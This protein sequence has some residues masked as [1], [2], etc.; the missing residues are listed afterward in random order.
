MQH[1]R[2]LGRE[3]KARAEHDVPPVVEDRVVVAE[4]DVIGV[5]HTPHI[6]LAQD[7]AA[8]ERL[9]DEHRARAFRCGREKVQV[10][11]EGAAYRARNAD[12]VLES[13]PAGAYRLHDEV[14]DDGTALGPQQAIVA[15]RV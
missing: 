3:A 8:L 7:L 9:R 4:A 2:I 10:L 13:R 5:D 12:V 1:A 11:P 14:T 6:V 15:E